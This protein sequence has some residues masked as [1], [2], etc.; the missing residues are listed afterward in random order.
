MKYFTT[1]YFFRILH[2]HVPRGKKNLSKQTFLKIHFC[3]FSFTQKSLGEL[4]ANEKTDR[5][6]NALV[7]LEFLEIRDITHRYN[8]CGAYRANFFTSVSNMTPTEVQRSAR[9]FVGQA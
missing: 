8:S 5:M 9:L 6:I 7:G 2:I 3:P 4:S 1:F